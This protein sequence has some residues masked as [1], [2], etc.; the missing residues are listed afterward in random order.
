MLKN[1]N[2]RTKSEFLAALSNGVLLY[3]ATQD[4]RGKVCFI[5]HTV[6]MCTVFDPKV[7]YIIPL[8]VV[9]E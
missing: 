1:P 2:S 9:T 6:C 7:C 4:Q 8:T 3:E 5:F